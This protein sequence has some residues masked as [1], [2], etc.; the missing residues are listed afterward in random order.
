ML[1]DCRVAEGLPLLPV[2]SIT[3]FPLGL[4]GTGPGIWLVVK[5]HN[6]C[7]HCNL[8]ADRHAEKEIFLGGSRAAQ[9]VVPSASAGQLWAHSLTITVENGLFDNLAP[10]LFSSPRS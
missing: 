3:L 4:L 6:S 10:D 2:K 8:V 9:S 1:L 5:M 7:I